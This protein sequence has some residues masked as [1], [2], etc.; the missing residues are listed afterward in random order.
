MLPNRS[1]LCSRSCTKLTTIKN[2]QMKTRRL[3]KKTKNCIVISKIPRNHLTF[4]RRRTKSSKIHLSITCKRPTHSK[5]TNPL[6]LRKAAGIRSDLWKPSTMQ[7]LPKST[8]GNSQNFRAFSRK[9][10]W[11]RRRSCSL[12]SKRWP[13]SKSVTRLSSNKGWRSRNRS[14]SWITISSRSWAI[15]RAHFK[16]RL[17]NSLPKLS[18][19][20][21]LKPRKLKP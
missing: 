8:R 19:L 16:R 13:N 21:L 6:C 17:K 11:L 5:R 7:R 12:T 15:R 3:S 20:W 1:Q 14:V 18:Q 4:L 10:C 2:W 9:I